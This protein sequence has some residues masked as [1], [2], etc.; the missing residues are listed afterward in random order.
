MHSRRE[1]AKE[2]T[3]GWEK[4]L[5]FR[6]KRMLTS[7][8]LKQVTRTILAIHS[9]P[10]YKKMDPSIQIAGRLHRSRLCWRGTRELI[11]AKFSLGVNPW[12]NVFA[13]ILS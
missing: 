11:F 2:R 5:T 3:G 7:T 8:I 1:D 13:Y 10:H 12:A 4:E 9:Q 6:L